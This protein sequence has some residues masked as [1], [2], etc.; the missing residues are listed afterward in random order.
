MLLHVY[1]LYF[2][3]IELNSM[4]AYSEHIFSFLKVQAKPGKNGAFTYCK[5]IQSRGPIL[6]PVVHVVRIIHGH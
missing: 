2:C 5:T 1:V 4:Y 6:S 3:Y